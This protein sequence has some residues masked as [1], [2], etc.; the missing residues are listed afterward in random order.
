VISATNISCD[1]NIR[2]DEALDV[3]RSEMLKMV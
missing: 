1:L 2:G 3:T